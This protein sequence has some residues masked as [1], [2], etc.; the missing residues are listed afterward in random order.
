MGKK[1]I[2]KTGKERW[3]CGPGGGKRGKDRETMNWLIFFLKKIK[4]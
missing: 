4:N 3:G 2:E 1:T